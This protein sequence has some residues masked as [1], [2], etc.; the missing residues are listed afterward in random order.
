MPAL[1]RFRQ[2]EDVEPTD[3]HEAGRHAQ[4]AMTA[5]TVER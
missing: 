2:W 4:I 1:L 3:A 5:E